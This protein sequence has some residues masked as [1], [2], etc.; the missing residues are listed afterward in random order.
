VA[1]LS[2]REL[3][4]AEVLVTEAGKSVRAVASDLGVDESTLR[5]RLRRRREGAVDGRARQ[6]EA[7]TA[8]R[9]VIE[10]W[11]ERHAQ[12]SIA[13]SSASLPGSEATIR[14]YASLASGETPQTS[15]RKRVR[16]TNCCHSGSPS[17]A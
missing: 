6:P 17:A 8:F 1:K 10:A 11:V 2:E 5:Y 3:V 13:C 12:A 16:R 15:C 14:S 9:D 7:A 4:C